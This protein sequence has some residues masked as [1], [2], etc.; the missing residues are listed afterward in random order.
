VRV[1]HWTGGAEA[2]LAGKRIA[3]PIVREG[4]LSVTLDDPRA[5]SRLSLKST[6]GR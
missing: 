5:K 1:H 2:F 6:A 4:V 3:D